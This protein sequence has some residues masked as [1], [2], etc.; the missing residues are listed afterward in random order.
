MKQI[1]ICQD[2]VNGLYSAIHD[3][4]KESRD[5]D[6]EIEIQGKEQ[7]RLFCEY[8]IVEPSGQ[9]ALRLERMI[10][11]HLGHCVYREFYYALLSENEEKA[12]A[13]FRSMQAARN[14]SDS[15]RIMEHLSDPNVAKVFA[16]SRSVSNEAHMY[17]EFIRFRELGNGVLVSEISP[18]A[19]ILTCVAD[20]FSD[21]FPLENWAIYDKTHCVFL[22]HRS[23][24]KWKLVW[25]SKWN[26]DI[27]A[28]ISKKEKEYEILWK[29]FF[30]SVSIH[31]RENQACQR[32]HLPL[33]FRGDITEFDERLAGENWKDTGRSVHRK[34]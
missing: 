22:I 9:K 26:G 23:G 6:A 16:M 11:R 29:N 3:A 1:Y 8:R 12:T 25:N 21:R 19:Q 31:E 4:W 7:T 18:K 24:Q 10:R 20:H 14:I 28:G 32:N 17:E 30:H 27:V 5:T 15:T 13:V 33:R 34:M 2:T